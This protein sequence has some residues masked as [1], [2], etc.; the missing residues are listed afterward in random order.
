MLYLRDIA[1]C[2]SLCSGLVQFEVS[3]HKVYQLH[4]Y[5]PTAMLLAVGL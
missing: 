2:V 4:S 3:L 1:L 5:S